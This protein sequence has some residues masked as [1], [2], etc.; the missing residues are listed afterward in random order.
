[1]AIET[2]HAHDA[3]PQ[4]LACVLSPADQ[5]TRL[6]EW[7]ALRRDG[8]LRETRERLVWTSLWRP[9]EEI[10]A[11][12]EALIE[13]EKACCSFITFELDDADGVV[14]LRTLF[15]QSA[16]GMAEAFIH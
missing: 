10:R 14:R 8:L 15:P 9:S 4:P 11:R 2:T 13:A 12:L 7:R 5:K 16:E 3:A 1:M 6:E